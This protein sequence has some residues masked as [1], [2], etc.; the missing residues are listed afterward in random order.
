MTAAFEREWIDYMVNNRYDSVTAVKY[1]FIT[2]DPAAC[3][4][5][6]YYVL[7]SMFFINGLCVVCLSFSSSSSY[8]IYLPNH[9]PTH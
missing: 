9:M 8:T 2:I 1:L 4:D 5:Q 3:K 7:S 6:N